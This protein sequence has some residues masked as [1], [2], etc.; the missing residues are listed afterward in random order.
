MSDMRM[1]KSKEIPGKDAEFPEKERPI[2]GS[3]G[4]GQR[5]FVTSHFGIVL[6]MASSLMGM[7]Q[8]R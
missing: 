7:K 6:D 8:R 4:E 2:P 5:N 3:G 1:A